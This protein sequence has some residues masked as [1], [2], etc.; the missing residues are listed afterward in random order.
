[1]EPLFDLIFREAN[2]GDEGI[3]LGFL[4]HVNRRAGRGADF[5]GIDLLDEGKAR[6][7]FARCGSKWVIQAHSAHIETV[8]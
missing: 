4:S 6:S 5:V 7:P 8:K 2:S 3:E 1:M